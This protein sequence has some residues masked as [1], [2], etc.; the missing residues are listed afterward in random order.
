MNVH[1]KDSFAED[2]NISEI[3]LRGS[4][5]R[6]V[7]L[8]YMSEEIAPDAG[9]R[10][11]EFFEAERHELRE[12]WHRKLAKLQAIVEEFRVC[13]AN[14]GG[15]L[16][17]G[18]SMT[19]QLMNS[20]E[21]TLRAARA[22]PREDG[23][24]SVEV[25][26]HLMLEVVEKWVQTDRSSRTTKTT[27]SLVIALQHNAPLLAVEVAHAIVKAGGMLSASTVLCTIARAVRGATGPE[28]IGGIYRFAQET[29]IRG[30][31]PVSSSKTVGFYNVLLAAAGVPAPTKGR[32]GPAYRDVDSLD[33]AERLLS[34]APL[35]RSVI[36]ANLPLSDQESEGRINLFLRAL[37]SASLVLDVEQVRIWESLT[38][39]EVSRLRQEVGACPK[40]A[41]YISKD[42]READLSK[43][44]Q[45]LVSQALLLAEAALEVMKNAR[46]DQPLRYEIRGSTVNLLSNAAFFCESLSTKQAHALLSIVSAA[47]E[48]P[49]VRR[50]MHS[51]SIENAVLAAL[52]VASDAEEEL[53]LLSQSCSTFVSALRK[54]FSFSNIMMSRVHDQYGRLFA[55]QICDDSVM[56]DFK[57]VG[58]RL[59]GTSKEPR[60]RNRRIG[61]PSQTLRGGLSSRPSRFVSSFGELHDS[62]LQKNGAKDLGK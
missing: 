10:G 30:L 43:P 31:V 20:C 35:A 61:N 3:G 18:N 36:E 22:F 60:V 33:V 14:S 40:L 21:S 28:H 25:V 59:A 53:S 54:G 57:Y 37:C 38:P 41:A 32:V 46:H 8:Y 26:G 6:A 2:G 5:R 52:S 58:R 11:G 45:A 19:T 51:A 12:Q 15:E 34:V 55:A 48:L 39:R 49:R 29:L 44:A 50:K 24:S 62:L 27:S 47:L 1:S 7:P 17:H 4:G 13:T 23:R 16:R 56:D 9:H 42:R